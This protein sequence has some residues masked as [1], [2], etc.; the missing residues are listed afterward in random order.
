[1]TFYNLGSDNVRQTTET[2]SDGGKTWTQVW[3]GL[4][5]RRKGE[6]PGR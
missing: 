5:V 1:M 2:S 6:A 3:D 4:Y